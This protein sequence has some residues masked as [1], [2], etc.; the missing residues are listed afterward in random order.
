M[1][2]FDKAWRA[3]GRAEGGHSDD[4]WDSGG[5]TNHGITEG[6]AR[7]FGY[8]GAMIDL[9]P[10]LARQIAKQKYW[11]PLNLDS[12]AEISYAVAFEVF[13]TGFNAGKRRA[14]KILQRSLN[15]LNRREKDYPD[16]I[17]DGFIGEKSIFA[18]QEFFRVRPSNGELVILRALNGLQVELYTELVERRKKDERFYFGWLLTRVVM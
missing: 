7:E 10:E 1:T 12:V 2:G 9:P 8:A 13:D 14:A 18:L 6:V 3:T 4:L 11:D 16:V 17:R 15:A 5:E